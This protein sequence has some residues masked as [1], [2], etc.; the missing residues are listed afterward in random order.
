M[1]DVPVPATAPAAPVAAAAPAP[2]APTTA[3]TATSAAAVWMQ[4][5]AV[6]G[7]KSTSAADP[8]AK[9]ADAP[10]AAAKPAEPA[11]PE[12]IS[13]K[14]P[15]GVTIEAARLE[16]FGADMSALGVTQDV[17]QKLFER[18]MAS[19][20]A[21]READMSAM[22]AT[23]DAWGQQ[24]KAEWG[25][26]YG[27]NAELTKRGFD[28][29]DPDGSMRKELEGINAHNWPKLLNGIR[30]VGEML[31]EDKLHAPSGAVPAPKISA[32]ER[33]KRGYAERMAG[34]KK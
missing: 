15:E 22:K 6:D 12:K 9:P 24:L 29:I 16:K 1:A 17:A 32:E 10:P 11:K 18:E 3:S 19:E 4:P 30:K 25:E 13:V 26:K 34:V 5:P 21:S 27:E 28:Y 7:A 20:K 33:L 8:A 14:A 2:A 31:R 23:N